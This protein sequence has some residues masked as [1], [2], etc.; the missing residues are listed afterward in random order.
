MGDGKEQC[1]ILVISLQAIDLPITYDT[2]L[3]GYSK[4]LATAFFGISP[5][6]S[7]ILIAQYVYKE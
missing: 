6:Q 7:T 1:K 5:M 3:R 2:G 4:P